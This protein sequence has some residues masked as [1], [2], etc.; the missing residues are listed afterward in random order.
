M[1]ATQAGVTQRIANVMAHSK[2]SADDVAN[3]IF[4]SQKKGEFWVLSHQPE[5]KLWLL[6]R[7]IPSV[8]SWL[9]QKKVA[10]LF[11]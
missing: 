7:Y 1:K 2:I 10:K 4:N 9:M 3:D 6:K 5:R 11:A 8:F